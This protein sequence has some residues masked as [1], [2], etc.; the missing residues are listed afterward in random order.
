M[1]IRKLTDFVRTNYG[2][3]TGSIGSQGGG[4]GLY[5]YVFSSSTA[6]SNGSDVGLGVYGGGGGL[7]RSA[8]NRPAPTSQQGAVRIILGDNYNFSSESSIFVRPSDYTGT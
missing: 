2:T 7:G 3:G 6:G 4:T 8:R 1:A 5:G